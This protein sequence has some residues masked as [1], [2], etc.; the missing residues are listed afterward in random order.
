MAAPPREIRMLRRYRRYA[1][2]GSFLAIIAAAAFGYEMLTALGGGF[3]RIVP[4]AELWFSIDT[5]SLNLVQA[6]V[7]R[8][9]H[10]VLWDPVIAGILQWPL[11]SILGGPGIAMMII[12]GQARDA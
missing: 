2:L 3:W 10:P 12:Y 11:W 5:G 4:T 1:R 7:Q 9:L 6:V 8:Y